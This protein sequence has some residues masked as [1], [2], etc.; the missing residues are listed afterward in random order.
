MRNLTGIV[1]GIAVALGAVEARADSVSYAGSLSLQ[2]GGLVGNWQA[3]GSLTWAVSQLAEQLWSYE[4]TVH[5]GANDVWDLVF[6]TTEDITPSTGNIL[7]SVPMFESIGW[8]GNEGIYGIVFA[9]RPDN[10]TIAFQSDRAPMWGDFLATNGS[11]TIKN[12]GFDT[13]DADRYTPVGS[14]SLEDHL[15]VPDVMRVR[16]PEPAALVN[17]GA[18]S[19]MLL[20]GLVWSR[21]RPRR[22]SAS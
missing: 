8:F 10:L 5:F 1:L 7:K 21:R 17:C 6:E 3:G 11:A 4:Y 13:Q 2:D 19:V 18:V 14:G 16:V 20:A 9:G 12:A 22:R 15:L